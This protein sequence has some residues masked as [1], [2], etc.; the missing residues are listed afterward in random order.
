MTKRLPFS[1]AV[2]KFLHVNVD[3]FVASF[4]TVLALVV[5]SEHIQRHLGIRLGNLFALPREQ[6]TR[7]N[8]TVQGLPQCSSDA[9]RH[10]LTFE[11][12]GW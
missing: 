1:G 6:K 12:A 8:F 3:F 5:T 9:M 7:G 11:L 10:A 2:I 4:A